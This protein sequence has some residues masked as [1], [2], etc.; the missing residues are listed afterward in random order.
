MFC[1]NCGQENPDEAMFC[2]Y[3]GIALKKPEQTKT[4]F[5]T[6]SSNGKMGK[7]GIILL[8]GLVLLAGAFFFGTKNDETHNSNQTTK[9][10]SDK[11]AS[12]KTTSD[13]TTS[14]RITDKSDDVHS[15]YMQV[16][17]TFVG[18]VLT[19]EDSEEIAQLFPIQYFNERKKEDILEGIE[20][21]KNYEEEDEEEDE[22]A[23]VYDE[24][25]EGT[26]DD[27]YDDDEYDYY[28][29]DDQYVESINHKAID[30]KDET[31]SEFLD[32]QKRYKEE[33]NVE[34]SQAKRVTLELSL[35]DRSAEMKLLVVEINGLWY[36]D[37]SYVL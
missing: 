13:K 10:A 6:K 11:T 21:L 28:Y 29:D 1:P 30:S 27:Y 23:D 35:E 4:N 24:Y 18:Y 32:I 7:K 14:D 22:E 26:D 2:Q 34:V 37:Y 25:E 5:K 19:K 12:D 8:V 16:A 3:C 17:D 20:K 15:D 9:T 33:L 36:V 31:N